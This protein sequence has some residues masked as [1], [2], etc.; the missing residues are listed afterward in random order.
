MLY[1][2][3]LISTDKHIGTHV[4]MSINNFSVKANLVN[5]F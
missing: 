4:V 3:D 5:L 1:F 2:L